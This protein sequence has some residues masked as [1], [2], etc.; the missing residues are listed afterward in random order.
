MKLLRYR[1]GEE[2]LSSD[3][4]TVKCCA[5]TD[6][7]CLQKQTAD[8]FRMWRYRNT[9]GRIS[10]PT[11]PPTQFWRCLWFRQDSRQGEMRFRGETRI[12]TR[13]KI[14]LYFNYIFT[15]FGM[16]C[17]SGRVTMKRNPTQFLVTIQV[18]IIGKLFLKQI[19]GSY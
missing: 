3:E 11:T 4:T 16:I 13:V 12:F 15:N 18:A 10:F 17:V 8:S 14:I 19:S 2:K 6:E 5:K 9:D 7:N 1:R